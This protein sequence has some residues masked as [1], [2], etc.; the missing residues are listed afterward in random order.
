[1]KHSKHIKAALAVTL[2]LALLTG[3]A[4]ASSGPK[5]KTDGRIIISEAGDYTL[6]GSMKGT[7]YVDPGAGDVTLTLDNVSIDSGSGPAIRAVSGDSLTL[8]TAP[9]SVNSITGNG[10]TQ[11]I[12]AA[13][14]SAAPVSFQNQGAL[15]VNG[16]AVKDNLSGSRNSGFV[17]LLREL[18][19]RVAAVF[20]NKGAAKNTA[21]FVQESP[22]YNDHDNTQRN[23]ASGEPQS[24]SQSQNNTQ[25]SGEPQGGDQAP[26]SGQPQS[27]SQPQNN[28]QASG[29][30][31]GGISSS[32]SEAGEIASGITENSAMSL[33]ADYD[34]AVT[35]TVTDEDGDVTISDAGTYVVTGS[36]SS[37]SITVKKG[38]TGVVL[39][40]DDL[41]LTSTGGATLSVNKQAEVQIVVSGSVTLT[42][43]E[44]PADE[45]SA[46][47][48]V[49]DA[50]DGAAIKVKAE[51]VVFITGDGTLT[52]NGDAKNGI[53]AGDDSSLIIGGDVTVDITAANDG[54]NGNY[55][56][57]ILSGTV[58]IDAGDDGIHADHILTIGDAETGAG[59]DI[60]ITRSTEGLEGT[61]VNIFGGDID[62][63][64]DDDGV[65]AA[66]KDAAYEGELGY[67]INMTGGDLSVKAGGD[68]LDSNGDI[69][70][71]GGSADIHSASNGGEA[72]IDYDG[73]LYISPD[74]DLNNASGVAGPDNMGSMG[75]RMSGMQGGGSQEMGAR[76]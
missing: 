19:S 6:T 67:A 71:V 16:G 56:V 10:S 40:L 66:N 35:Y 73:D 14:K 28:T 29:E 22:A 3:T 61:V 70:L 55:D 31:Q 18:I 64:S 60:D 17:A 24:G 72:G 20:Q 9:G 2:C 75:G 13:V 32:V 27:G 8:K 76:R 21:A 34:N 23:D 7:V 39:V 57:T 51:S 47:E 45:D 53:K 62:V 4:L 74:F 12:S 44:D 69:N 1:M 48:A 37:G 25:V 26:T 52:I 49:A 50:F 58:T 63:T 30:P 38:T 5:E 68:G 15:R 33:E 65:N 43:A 59:P 11:K 36:S 42:D 46:D 54:I 41:D